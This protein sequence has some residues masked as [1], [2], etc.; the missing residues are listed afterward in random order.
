MPLKLPSDLGI[1]YADTIALRSMNQETLAI[2]M[3]LELRW[4]VS[5]QCADIISFR[6]GKK[7]AYR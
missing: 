6:P 7:I 2:E 4:D 3:A 1:W 5:I